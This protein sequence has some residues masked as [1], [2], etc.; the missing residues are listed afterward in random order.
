[1]FC[2]Q[3]CTGPHTCGMFNEC[4]PLSVAPSGQAVSDLACVPNGNHGGAS[5]AACV[6]QS[7]CA[8]GMCVSG[9]CT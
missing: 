4:A 1:V 5:G 7:D 6:L 8:S 2:T 3:T 9:Q